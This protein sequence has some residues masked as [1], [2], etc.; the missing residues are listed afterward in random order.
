MIMDIFDEI[1]ILIS[2]IKNN[3]FI[4]FGIK[5]P[6]D[7]YVDIKCD[8]VSENS[9]NNLSIFIIKQEKIA[10]YNKVNNFDDINKIYKEL[11]DKL[12]QFSV[13]IAD[14]RD[15]N[16]FKQEIKDKLSKFKTE[17]DRSLKPLESRHKKLLDNC[18]KCNDTNSIIE[19]V[20]QTYKKFFEEKIFKAI[21]FPLYDGYRNDNDSSSY[22]W[23]ITK[24]NKILA[25]LG[26]YTLKITVGERIEINNNVDFSYELTEPKE[27]NSDLSN[28]IAKKDTVKNVLRYA[29]VFNDDNENY[30]IVTDGLLELWRFE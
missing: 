16:S 21:V 23:L 9:L 11:Y 15:N 3:C 10:F 7:N 1:R 14:F 17:V 6:Q 19:N 4:P 25:N 24:I 29:Y 8:I 30:S 27:D 26:I 13:D 20:V 5:L 28:D 18:K 22:E 2:E 12:E